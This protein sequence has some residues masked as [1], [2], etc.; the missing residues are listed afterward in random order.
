L[1]KIKIAAARGKTEKL[2]QFILAKAFSGELVETE[3]EIARR[4]CRDYET[5][6]VLLEKIK[7]EKGK[8]E[9]K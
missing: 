7:A 3:A 4:E 8:K 6:E 2:R 1:L 9:K 5:A